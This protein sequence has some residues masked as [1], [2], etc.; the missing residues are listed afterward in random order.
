MY[1]AN[2]WGLLGLLAIPVIVVIHLYH[3]RYPTLPIA[4]LHLWGVETH[5][6]TAGR[7]RE[8]LPLTASLIFEL[9]AALLLSL[10]LADPRWG[11]LGK[12]AHLVVVLDNSASMSAR[13]PGERPFRESAIVELERRVG[14]LPRGSVVTLLRTGR[15]P[16]MLAGPAVSWDVAQKKLA[17]WKPSLPK[18]NF[19]PTW[20][21]AAQLAEGSGTLLFLTDSV[22]SQDVVVPRAME[23]VSVGRMLENI[24]I[25]AARWDFDSKAAKGRVFVRLT[26]HGKQNANVR[27]A[28]LLGV[29]D[30]ANSAPNPEE[31]SD[32]ENASSKKEAQSKKR[33][34]ENRV[35]LDAGSSMPLEVEVPGGLSRMTLECE[36]IGDGLALDNRVELIEP[37]VRLLHVATMLPK[38]SAAEQA[39]SRVL[40]TLPDVSLTDSDSAELVIAPFDPLPPSQ[41]ELW[42]LGIGPLDTS[43]EARNAA[44]DLAGPYVLEKQNPLLDGLTLGGVVWGGVQPVRL[45]VS[46]IITTGALPLLSR[47]IGTRTTAYLLNIDFARTNLGDSPDWPILLSNLVELR[48]DNLPGLR[49]WNYR[50]NEEIRFR[51]SDS[52]TTTVTAST[53]D[54]R[55]AT[56]SSGIDHDV[57]NSRP[58]QL[59]HR[60]LKRPLARAS[61]IEIPPLDESGVYSVLDGEELV[62]EFA[63]AFFDSEESSLSHLRPGRREPEMANS[64]SGFLLDQPLTWIVL[65]GIALI[66]G[67]AFAD[68]NVLRSSG[69]KRR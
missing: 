35:S 61:T 14:Q 38:E 64:E 3:R 18:H 24:S 6:T 13:P 51:V 15:R 62:G 68:W 11:Q 60:G 65:I 29:T 36:S 2:P 41:R 5:T 4:G 37:K 55:S 33:I 63:V 58:L 53:T 20:D 39:V 12:V 57:D 10:V 42:W 31:K 27:V 50:M 25:S 69:G 54:D 19:L 23:V 32:L 30:K 44:L 7:T 34:F 67:V 22:P 16:E 28:G 49:R 26:N 1:F 43:E 17:D 59:V 47:L 45:E 40:K 46:P 8:R 9:F 52:A 48:R 21:L 66:V 56:T